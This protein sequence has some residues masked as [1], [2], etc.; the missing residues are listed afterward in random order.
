[1]F[2][3]HKRLDHATAGHAPVNRMRRRIGPAR[4]VFARQDD[5]NRLARYWSRHMTDLTLLT[6][7]SVS[8]GHPDKICDQIS[9]AILDACLATDPTAR[10]AVETAIKN[11][12][13]CLLG[14]ITTTA[15]PDYDAIV[16]EV[17]SDIGHQD[18]RWGLD[19]G[20]LTVVKALTRQSP[21]IA[22]GVNVDGAGDQGMMFGYA[23]RQTPGLMPV[24][25]SLSHQLLQR[26]SAFR[27]T[28]AGALL[29]PDAKAQVTVAYDQAGQPQKI[30]AIVLSTQHAAELSQPDLHELVR[31]EILKPVL[32]DHLSA[33]GAAI[34]I[35]PTG[36][37]VEGG[38]V[39][40]AGLTGRK[41]IVDTYG[42]AA[43]HGGG[44][45]S[46]KD[47]TKVDRSA[48]YAARQLARAVVESG[49]VEEA[50][51]QVSYAIGEARPVSITLWSPGRTAAACQ[52]ILRSVAPD[53]DELLT[54]ASIIE[55]LDLRRPIYRQTATY[56]HFG[57]SELPWEQAM[58]PGKAKAA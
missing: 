15:N 3:K 42:G 48:A 6:S 12:T 39:A 32:P 29:G 9:D 43:R 7:E 57:R 53:A 18:A 46:G 8:E 30:T 20:Q 10:V 31:E 35:N 5:N 41:I 40:D 47:P 54:P 23:T 55:R 58:L 17:L 22:Q 38:P 14:E 36:I 16:A 1:M 19:L 28:D 13:V 25:I 4:R 44:A 50:E 45:F 21:D 2:R 34:H 26:H 24:P 37:F 52:E 51:I 11:S 56:G 33:D 27:R 49:A